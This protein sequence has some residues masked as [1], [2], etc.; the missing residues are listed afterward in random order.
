MF[1]HDWGGPG[2]EPPPQSDYFPHQNKNQNFYYNPKLRRTPSCHH[3]HHHSSEQDLN[4]GFSAGAPSFSHHHHV[5]FSQRILTEHH[6]P[7][8]STGSLGR[9]Q[10]FHSHPLPVPVHHHHDGGP[11]VNR[12]Y[13]HPS[14]GFEPAPRLRRHES[15]R[16][17]SSNFG[18]TV[19]LKSSL[20]EKRPSF[21][22]RYHSA[23]RPVKRAKSSGKSRRFHSCERPSKS[24]N[25]HRNVIPVNQD[26]L[27]G[28][29]LGH[30]VHPPPQLQFDDELEQPQYA[31]N[32]S[33]R[34]R[35]SRS[36][37]PEVTRVKPLR[38][39][40]KAGTSETNVNYNSATLPLPTMKQ[41]RSSSSSNRKNGYSKTITD[42]AVSNVSN[43]AGILLRT[44]SSST[45]PRP[46]SS[47]PVSLPSKSS[48]FRHDKDKC[49]KNNKAISSPIPSI[50][51]L[52]GQMLHN[53]SVGIHQLILDRFQTIP[54]KSCRDCN[55]SVRGRVKCSKHRMLKP[56]EIR[57]LANF[58]RFFRS[59]GIENRT[60]FVRQIEIVRRRQA[61]AARKSTVDEHGIPDN[62]RTQL[63]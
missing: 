8:F 36:S 31:S 37:K 28:N 46:V 13:V 40:L 56:E 51:S 22:S 49:K 61:R 41:T 16:V 3:Y 11:F 12:I 55:S 57:K 20:V 9:V 38:A 58:R 53:Q 6:Q 21:A 60:E 17:S 54:G 45:L 48:S 23:E 63:R 35:K 42:N 34:P 47:L 26:T 33:K 4:L 43:P 25:L 52:A 27:P 5:P 50:S 44:G 7:Y 1:Y 29:I 15:H 14:A 39:K 19:L 62:S 32:S 2:G 24:S 18:S 30:H 59:A 10:S